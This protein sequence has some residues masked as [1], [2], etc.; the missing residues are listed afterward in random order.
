MYSFTTQVGNATTITSIMLM[1]APQVS[2]PCLSP[3]RLHTQ[4]HGVVH[5][6]RTHPHD[7]C[8][9]V[10]DHTW[11]HTAAVPHL[12]PL[13]L[14]QRTL[15]VLATRMSPSSLPQCASHRYRGNLHS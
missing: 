12:L 2:R 10:Q 5:K 11:P 8:S 6:L 9:V 15:H 13:S 14:L 3:P 4:G 7:C 1:S